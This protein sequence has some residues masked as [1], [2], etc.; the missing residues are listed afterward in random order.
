M[1]D[2]NYVWYVPTE[3]SLIIRLLKIEIKCHKVLEFNQHFVTRPI[4]FFFTTV[5]DRKKYTA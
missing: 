4:F 3:C 5:L 2:I 1:N